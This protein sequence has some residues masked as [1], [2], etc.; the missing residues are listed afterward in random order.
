MPSVNEYRD[1]IDLPP[2]AEKAAV[3]VATDCSGMD[4]PLWALRSVLKVPAKEIRYEWASD[5]DRAA[6]E[7]ISQQRERVHHPRRFFKDMTKRDHRELPH[8][9]VYVCGY[10]CQ[11]FSR[12][13]TRRNYEDP[14]AAVFEHVMRTIAASKPKVFVL[15]NVHTVVEYERIWEPFQEEMNKRVGKDYEVRVA[16]LNAKD[17]GVPQIRRRMYCLGVRREHIVA[18]VQVFPPPPRRE[19][20]VLAVAD[21]KLPQDAYL[22]SAET[23][24][25]IEKRIR[26]VGGDPDKEPWIWS[27]DESARFARATY[28]LSPTLLTGHSRYMW[29]SCLRRYLTPKEAALLQGFPRS[30]LPH[31]TPTRAYF[32]AGN[33]MSTGSVGSAMAAGLKMVGVLDARGRVAKR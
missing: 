3:A 14:R 27:S 29:V 28:A 20:D 33:S 7:T 19:V 2:G 30:F 24:A 23:R 15:E 21:K 26:E 1:P 32:Q 25:K 13:G 10:P 12:V 16:V 18:P 11:P 22:G 31:P 9:D 8:V 4:A 5:I 17:F 6:F